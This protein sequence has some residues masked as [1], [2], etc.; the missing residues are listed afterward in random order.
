MTGSLAW[1]T[2]GTIS[3]LQN[4][5]QGNAIAASLATF[6]QGPSA[7]TA[8]STGLAS[9]AG[10]VWHD[11]TNNLL[12]IRDQGDTSWITVGT[13]DETN[14]VFTPYLP[15]P[16]P[17]GRNRLVNPLILFD[18]R[19]EGN[20]QTLT[21]G[22]SPFA[23]DQWQV[24]F[25]QLPL[26]GGTTT[27]QVVS[28]APTGL[29]GSSGRSIK[30]TMG[31]GHATSAGD[32]GIIVQNIEAFNTADLAFGAAGAQPVS[33]SFWIKSSLPS[34]TFTAFLNNLNA[35][36]GWRTYLANFT[37]TG[38]STW[39]QV[40]IPDILG[41]LSGT[42]TKNTNGV[43]LQFGICF[44]AGST[45]QGTNNSW[46]GANVYG[47]G[48]T[49]NLLATTGA[50]VQITGLQLESGPACT[51]LDIRHYSEELRRCQRY[52]WKSFPQGTAPATNAGLT[53]ALAG[54][55]LSSASSNGVIGWGGFP[56]T[57]RGTPVVSIFNPSAGNN[58]ARSTASGSDFSSTTTGQLSPSGWIVVAIAPGTTSAG[59]GAVFHLAAEAGL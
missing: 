6:Q 13:F 44:G 49:T 50:T 31:T 25:I 29:G 20:A 24:Q 11:T 55:Q 46:N 40:F 8:S 21:S 9:T 1:A 18:Q 10:V 26:G 43:G 2:S 19:Q 27:S 7:P 35:G 42:W 39:Q 33:A 3:G 53:G 16:Y 15:P 14:K 17:S 36:G 22:I 41:D 34:P 28:D 56:V 54:A 45:F 38:A 23:A 48:S 47:T 58:Q 51:A 59:S 52:Y 30:F 57:M 12:K 5:Q 37:L 4:N 32:F